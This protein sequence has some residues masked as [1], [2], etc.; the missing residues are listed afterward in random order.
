VDTVEVR[1]SVPEDRQDVCIARLE[2]L[3]FDGFWTEAD[4]LRAY[5]PAPRWTDGQREEVAQVLHALDLPASVET[6]TLPD[7]DWNAAWE[8][9]IEPVRAG[10]FVVAPTWA[11]LDD[12]DGPRR[13]SDDASD[14]ARAGEAPIVIRIDPKMSFGTGYHEST[15]LALRLLPACRP[16]GASVLDAGT[17][18]GILAIAAARLGADR[19]LAFDTD[20]WAEANARENVAA[21]DAAAA[22]TVRRGTLDVVPESGFEVICANINRATLLDL[23]P[24]F[25]DKLA[26]AGHLLLSG[27]LQSDRDALL[28]A[29][30]AHGLTPVEEATENEWW[31]TVLQLL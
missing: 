11:A 18:T 5:V 14:E 25:A 29:G 16:D 17:G 12:A 3:G 8:E 26:P 27:L 24:R 21:N 19:V 22:I 15:R 4:A 10:R 30:S 13:A 9:T 6:R 20:R 23:M 1:L 7:Q 2:A 31:A 28:E